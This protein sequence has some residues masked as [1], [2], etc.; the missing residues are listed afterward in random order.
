MPRSPKYPLE[1]LLEHRERKVDDATAELGAAVRARETAEDAKRRAQRER[2]AAEERAVQVRA[3]E[4]E[5]LAKG[6]LRAADLATAQ[7]WELGVR[8]AITDL[9][10]IEATAGVRAEDARAAEDNARAELARQKADRDVV[11]KD[12][13]RFADDRRRDA[14]A[15]EE[16]NAEDAHRAGAKRGGA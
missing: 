3:E 8:H 5:R 12:R 4:A 14:E 1:P 7:Q 11:A 15:A 6:E 13:A 10:R 16:E 9:A 2:A